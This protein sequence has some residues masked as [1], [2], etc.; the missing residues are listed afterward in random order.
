MRIGLPLLLPLLAACGAPAGVAAE[1]RDESAGKALR[2][3]SPRAAHSAVVLPD[4]RVLLVG[5]CV[6]ASCEAGPAS[7]TVEAFDPTTRRFSVA[8]R[9]DSRRTSMALVP[10]PSGELLIAGGWSGSSVT[11]RL[12]IFD[13]KT[14]T[15]RNAGRLSAARADIAAATLP[16][17][18]ILL[19]GGYADGKALDLVEVFDP[20]DGGVAE[21]GRLASGRAG[22]GAALLR[23]G[24]ILLV[25][26]GISG[27]DGVVPTASAEIFDPRRGRST[28]A[29][30]LAGP[31]YKHAVVTL[32]DGA[33]F[34]LGGSDAR[35]NR[36]K[37]DLVE[38][39]DPATGR[40]MPAGRLL[41]KR[42]KI[43]GAV[44]LLPDG[45]LLIA[46]GAPRAELYDPRTQRS[47]F[48]GPDM[49]ASL[50]F[51]TTSLLRSGQVLVAGGYDEQGIKM[52][53]RAWLI[54]PESGGAGR[55]PR[56]SP[57]TLSR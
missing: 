23:D 1:A 45:R 47:Q 38:L 55:M 41:A 57:S 48:V 29:G 2:M 25:G 11:D 7:A 22:A 10:L 36:G 13:P 49:A 30:S 6:L 54:D 39:F 18:R 40:F 34:V 52:S 56:S 14:G 33:V 46:G 53:D 9:L 16:D 32:P 44:V 19:A 51:A 28:T 12:E 37:T 20:S 3:S 31:R 42:Y 21:I 5:G 8:G 50:N 27:S 15:A 35:D 17:G 24:R 4:G 26:G 43:G